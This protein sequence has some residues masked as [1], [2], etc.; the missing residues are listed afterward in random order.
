MWDPAIV[1]AFVEQYRA[2]KQNG[3]ARSLTEYQARFPGF[4][5]VIAS[6]Y[7]DL[8]R[9]ESRGEAAEGGERWVGP[10]KVL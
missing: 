8:Q 7:A 1:A 4:E 6:E 5:G 9:R 10:F 3:R 2:D